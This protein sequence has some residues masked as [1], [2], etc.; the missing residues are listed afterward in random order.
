MRDITMVLLSIELSKTS[1]SS[2]VALTPETQRAIV[3]ELV[4]QMGVPPTPHLTEKPLPVIVE[5]TFLMNSPKSSPTNLEPSQWPT[6]VNQTVVDPNSL[7]T[8]ST[9]HSP[10]G[11]TSPP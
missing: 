5:E 11:L 7:L 3:L 2:L 1:C 4:A 8:L 9:I 10:T 6:L